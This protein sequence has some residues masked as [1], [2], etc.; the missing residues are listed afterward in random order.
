MLKIF[1]QKNGAILGIFFKDIS[2]YISSMNNRKTATRDMSWQ[3]MLVFSMFLAIVSSRKVSENE[4]ASQR[5]EAGCFD[6]RKKKS[7]SA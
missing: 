7:K 5:T 4:K 3:K 6:S 1:R 2:H